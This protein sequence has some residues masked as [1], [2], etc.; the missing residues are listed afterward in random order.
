MIKRDNIKIYKP[1]IS[2]KIMAEKDLA[3]IQRDFYNEKKHEILESGHKFAVIQGAKVGFYD[4]VDTLYSE[5]P[6][7]KPGANSISLMPIL[8][9]VER[10]T[11]ST[12]YK[13]EKLTR[14]VQQ[15]K[16]TLTNLL[17]QGGQVIKQGCETV[18]L[19]EVRKT[20]EKAAD[21][22]RQKLKNL[23]DRLGR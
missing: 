23:K 9:D 17:R 12:E 5:H 2:M 20:V 16:G 1:R 22:A 21:E 7:F 14:D 8:I 6:Y 3:Q 10:E 11:A 18:D 4:S 15:L 19:T 13:R